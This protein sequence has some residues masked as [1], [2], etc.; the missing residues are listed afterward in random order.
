[1]FTI[2]RQ[3]LKGVPKT[4]LIPLW[5]RAAESQRPHFIIKD[6]LALDMVNKIDYDFSTFDK[7]WMTRLVVA[8]RT[9]ILDRE[10]RTFIDKHPEAI[11]INVGLRP[12]HSLFQDRQRPDTLV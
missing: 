4:L 9:E 2:I 8:I 10:V 12:R 1:V 5:A 7:E 11:V 3:D 6:P